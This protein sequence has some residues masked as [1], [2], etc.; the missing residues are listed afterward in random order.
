MAV[1]SIWTTVLGRSLRQSESGH[2]GHASAPSSH[3]RRRSTFRIR[4]CNGCSHGQLQFCAGFYPYLILI[5][6]TRQIPC[7]MC[8]TVPMEINASV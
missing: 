8:P 1:N 2:L 7:T 5:S 6:H 3:S 4:R